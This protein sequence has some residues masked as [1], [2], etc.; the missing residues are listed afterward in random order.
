MKLDEDAGLCLFLLNCSISFLLLFKRLSR[1]L[2]SKSGFRFWWYGKTGIGLLQALKYLIK[3]FV[4]LT[5]F[6]YFGQT[7][8]LDSIVGKSNLQTGQGKLL[9]YCLQASG[10]DTILHEGI[11]SIKP[12]T[13]SGLVSQEPKS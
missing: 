7:Y 4:D 12:K 13:S 8:N 9:D 5:A 11:Q 6:P 2:Y 3:P 1:V 10:I